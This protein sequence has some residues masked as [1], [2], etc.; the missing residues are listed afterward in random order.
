MKNTVITFVRHGQTTANVEK[1][2]CGAADVLLTEKGIEQSNLLGESLSGEVYDVLLSGCTK[3]VKNTAEN[4]LKHLKTKPSVIIFDENIKEI[5]FG[6]FESKN[7][8]EL[9]DHKCWE[10]YMQNWQ[11]FTFPGG[12]NT[13]EFF[14]RCGAFI[15]RIKEEYRSKNIIIFAS[16]GFI[17]SCI[18]ALKNLD[19]SHMFDFEYENCVPLQ[20]KVM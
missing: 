17:S 7:Y 6:E 5:N 15:K 16:K 13:K 10:E 19:I 18:C 20:I 4:V 11:D 3:R 8:K 12:D 1:L 9:K 2:F 14:E